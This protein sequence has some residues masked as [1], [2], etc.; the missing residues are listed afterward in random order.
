MRNLLILFFTL[1]SLWSCK[2]KKTSLSGAEKVEIGD[3]IEFFPETKLPI[4]IAD[5]AISRKLPDAT[6][7]SLPVLSNFIPDSLFTREFG[8][9]GKPKFYAIGRVADK[10]KENYLFLKAATAAKQVAYV[11]VFSKDMKYMAGMPIVRNSNT[12]DQFN[13]GS[14]DSKYTIAINKQRKNPD[15]QTY[16][17]KDA[18]VYNSEGAFTLILTESNELLQSKVIDN[19]IDTMRRNFKFSGDYVQD[20]KNMVSV[21]DG[22]KAGLVMVFIH[23]EKNKGDCTGE[24]KG[25]FAM[26]SASTAVYRHIGDACAVQLDFTNTAVKMKELEG[27]GN[28]RDIRCLFEGTYTKK[29]VAKPKEVKGKSKK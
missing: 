6:N 4:T 9:E 7:I 23:F 3:F 27:C 20:A 25:E 22:R 26:T 18:Y 14:M 2:G 8:K 19:P 15:G 12:R 5:T 28:H 11:L 16:Y 1:L 13:V 10:N 17:K 29:K 21:R 24:L